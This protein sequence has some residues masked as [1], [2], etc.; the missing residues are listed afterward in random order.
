MLFKAINR[1]EIIKMRDKYVPGSNCVREETVHVHIGLHFILRKT[2]TKKG[3]C[4]GGS[5]SFK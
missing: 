4:L 2:L 3:L 1:W 5:L